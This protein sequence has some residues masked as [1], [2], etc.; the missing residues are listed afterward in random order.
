MIT[1]VVNFFNTGFLIYFCYKCINNK[2]DTS[3]LWISLSILYFINIPLLYDSLFSLFQTNYELFLVKANEN[4]EMGTFKN[5]QLISF[6][7][8]IFN[9]IM[10]ITYLLVN[11]TFIVNRAKKKKLKIVNNEKIGEYFQLNIIPWWVCILI[12]YCGLVLF[13]VNN[14][15]SGIT[16][17]GIV[18]WYASRTHNRLLNFISPFLLL[19]SSFPIFKALVEKKY[20]MGVIC[21]IPFV[22][23]GYISSARSLIISAI[24]Y[25][26]YYYIL[27]LKSLSLKNVMV[28]IIFAIFISTI[29]TVWRGDLEMMY[30]NTKDMSYSDLFYAYNI[31]EFFTTLGNNTLR[32]IFTG[33]YRFE[34]YDVTL[35]L[36]DYKYHQGWGSLHPTILGWAYIDLG[37]YFWLFALYIGVFMG[38]CDRIRLSCKP[39]INLIFLSF[40]FSFSTIAVRGSVQ[41]AYSTLIYPLII[42]ILY[43]LL[44]RGKKTAKI[45]TRHFHH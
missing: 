32:L 29:L 18:E 31:S 21:S 37:K 4:W 26:L 27:K 19:L 6:S 2:I 33:F 12:S 36:A 24:F 35:A 22:I 43:K 8:A 13:F 41:Y 5:L 28:L 44:V 30:P 3:L 10:Y 7:S 23:V 15:I 42:L 14:G 38:I 16:Q 25:I 11:P 39:I 1:L 9:I 20:L 17:M 45:S 40:I 34:A